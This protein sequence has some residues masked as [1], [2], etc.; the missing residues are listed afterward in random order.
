[1]ADLQELLFGHLTSDISIDL[2]TANTLVYV[3]GRG[4]VI[5]EP[6]VVATN[7]VTGELVAVGEAARKMVGRTPSTIVAHRPLKDGVISNFEVAEA[8]L[9]YFIERVHHER[10][11]LFARPRVIIGI[12]YQVTEVE[13]R[14]ALEGA[15]A[16][17]ARQVFLIEEPIA[18]ALGA[19]LPIEE[20]VGSLIV[21][22]GGGTTEVAVISC[23]G[24]VTSR[25]LRLAGDELSEEIVNFVR[26]QHNLLIGLRTG[27]ELK[28]RLGSVL[29][30]KEVSRETIRGRD[31]VSGMPRALSISD[32]EIREALLPQVRLLS[33]Q[34]RGALE[35][36]P[37]ELLSDIMERGVCLS[38]GGALLR[39][40]PE[41]LAA[42]IHSKVYVA[43][44][45]MTCV[46]R[47]AGIVLED[48]DQLKNVLVPA[49]LH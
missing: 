20:P 23:G 41:W 10:F 49:A 2:G 45:P 43:D 5:N 12:P 14:A 47:G 40:L 22:I 21:D 7:T 39:G 15:Y 3:R 16:A 24:I 32:E 37:P 42:E 13:R 19:R 35:E 27:E 26:E 36:T 17:G 30:G 1:M 48:L 9:R 33:E 8:M 28:E 46:V 38:G 6:S 4:I 44:D 25:S 31:L 29:P 18:A 11:T 34:I